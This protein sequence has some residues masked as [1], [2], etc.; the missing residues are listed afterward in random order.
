M[1]DLRS[2][3]KKL[4][5]S[6]GSGSNARFGNQIVT[7]LYPV[8]QYIERDITEGV[9]ESTFSDVARLAI[10]VKTLPIGQRKEP[11]L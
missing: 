7:V 11:T 2:E 1:M 3:A 9:A 6:T 10:P 8:M 4:E 5:T